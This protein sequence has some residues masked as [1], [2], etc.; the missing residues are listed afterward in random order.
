MSVLTWF[1]DEADL[2]PCMSEA[3]FFVS[4][5][6]RGAGVVGSPTEVLEGGWSGLSIGIFESEIVR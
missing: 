3:L 5:E 6:S 4:M 2:G 1:T